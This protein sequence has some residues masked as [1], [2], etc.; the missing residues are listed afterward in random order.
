MND[1]KSKTTKNRDRNDFIHFF[2]RFYKHIGRHPNIID[3]EYFKEQIK[4]KKHKEV[5]RQ[6]HGTNKCLLDFEE[7]EYYICFIKKNKEIH[8]KTIFPKEG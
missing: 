8:L 6:K 3:I 2:R 1:F 5:I 7:K 4:D